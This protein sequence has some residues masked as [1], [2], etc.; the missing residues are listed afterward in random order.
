MWDR[1]EKLTGSVGLQRLTDATI[2]V[3]GVGSLGS[4]TTLLLAMS[5]IGRF[6][7]I[8]PDT[9]EEDNVVRHAADLQYVDQ[10]KVEAVRDLIMNRNPNVVVE[11]YT[12][13]AR[14]QPEILQTADLVIVCGL[15]S[16][17]ATSQ[18]GAMIQEM[19]KPALYGGLYDMAVA[20]EIFFVDTKEGEPC[21]GC[22]ASVLR[23]SQPE[24]IIKRAVNYGVPLD[25][26]KAVPGLGIHV[27]GVANVLADWAVRLV[28]DDAEI[29]EKFPTN[30]VILSNSEYQAGTDQEGKPFIMKPASSY[31]VSISRD[32]DCLLCGLDSSQDSGSIDNLL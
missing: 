7:L 17:I 3:V 32:R 25:E 6:I 16:E 20:G 28:I 14:N 30:L 22:F 29:L 15:G 19:K 23:D 11:T 21:Y 31:W 5:G 18:L 8:D 24:P 1:V 9:L 12:V 10:P 2:A 27:L 26:V 4:W 13:D